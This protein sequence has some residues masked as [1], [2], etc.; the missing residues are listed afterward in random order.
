VKF[1][2]RQLFAQV[3]VNMPVAVQVGCAVMNTEWVPENMLV[4]VQIDSAVVNTD[5]VVGTLE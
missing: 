1:V 4:G 2:P 5:E 3:Q